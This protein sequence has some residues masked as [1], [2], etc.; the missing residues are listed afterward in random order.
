MRPGKTATLFLFFFLV[1][2]RLVFFV[3]A[4]LPINRR[5]GLFEMHL[6]VTN[7]IQ[8]LLGIQPFDLYV[9]VFELRFD[10]DKLS[11]NLT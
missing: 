9:L 5:S 6:V 11:R 4:L 3:N 10:G 1:V 8:S 2:V 7:R